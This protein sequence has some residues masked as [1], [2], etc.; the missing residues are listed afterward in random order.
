MSN[1]IDKKAADNIRI[2]SAAMVEKAK[3]GHP[4]GAMGGADFIHILFSEF[5]NYDPS[6]MEWPNRDRFFLDPGHMSPMLYS[7]LSMA[8]T[9]TMDDL[10]NFRQW[11][12]V[13]PGHPEKDVARGIENT[14]G[15]L[16]QGHSMAVGAAI[17]ER[18]LTTRFGDWMAHKIYT[19]ISDGGI[20]E[21]V[22]QG[23]GRIAGYLGL[24]NLIMFY[25]S[26]K[27][28]LS[29]K[30][31]VVTAED[32]AKKYEA[33]GW[34]VLTIDG[35]NQDQIREALK[36]ANAET[37]KPTLIVGETVMGKGAVT[38]DG[39]S[40]E[41]QTSTHGMPLSKAGGS[42]EKTIENLGGNPENPFQIFEEVKEFYNKR[43][44]ELIKA[45][46]DK[47]A[48][49]A[50]WEKENPELAQKLKTFFTDEA[51]QFD[52]SSV[53]Q[54]ENVATRGASGAVLA[55]MAGKVENLIV[56]SA[57]LSNSD[58][59]DGFL[60]KT[61]P[62]QKGDFSGS[63][64]QVG[65]S[66]LTMACLAN[67]MALHGGVIPVCGTFFVFSDYMKPAVRLAAL[68]ELPVKYV[69]THD[70]FR[71]GEDG[72]THQPV[73]QEAQIRLLE[74]LKNH[75]G[76]NSMLVLRPADGNETTAAWKM[77]VENTATP[78]ALILS[79][80]NIEN[81]PASGDP[82]QSALQTEK[83]AYIVLKPKAKP[84]VV[85]VAN[86]SEVSSLVD[87]AKLLSE[88]DNL[89]V[90]VV[91]APSEGL[92]RNQPKDYQESVLP[93]GI[94]RFGLTAGL[95]ETLTGLVGE[96]GSIWGMETFGFSAPY[97][98]LDEKLGFNGE[99]VYKQVKEMLS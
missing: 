93:T 34:N 15:P 28:Q 85:L 39:S 56:A 27:I 2:L 77:A 24:G 67:G 20:Q 71:V 54:K 64:L 7:V 84:D 45:A 88:K 65:V 42:F 29:T 69:W 23:A 52:F 53:E 57:D 80:Q 6:D 91:S 1:Q 11:G 75:S 59:T 25:D 35:N 30:T 97:K 73:E 43:K 70:A 50:K 36:K 72:P 51:P 90:Q 44:E 37:Q 21:E 62:L 3:S 74:K 18:F 32:T 83:G 96:N 92:F 48:Q 55:A 94:P 40:F 9:F 17:T 19:F 8:G 99:N 61:Q 10:K 78:T 38:E 76:E 87:G 89:N 86:G 22:S 81:I 79:R 4:G 63:F 46:A 68:M 13:T 41:S 33:W 16:G 49:Q 12:S 14:S 95:P 47:K 98:V 5:L 31:N 82:Y 66:E 26:N 60:K 58:K